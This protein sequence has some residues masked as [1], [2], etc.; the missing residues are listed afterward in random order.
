MPEVPDAFAPPDV[1]GVPDGTDGSDPPAATTAGDT[2]EE[3]RARG[4]SRDGSVDVEVDLRG[5]L[6]HLRI[7]PRALRGPHPGRV[8]AAVIEAL[9]EAGGQVIRLAHQNRRR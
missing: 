7:D 4:R 1:P 8:G 5:R 9:T 2:V 3:P 6:C